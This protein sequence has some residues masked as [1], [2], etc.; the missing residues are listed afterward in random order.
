[1]FPTILVV[2]DRLISYE[3]RSSFTRLKSAEVLKGK[4]MKLTFALPQNFTYQAGMYIQLNCDTVAKEEWHPFTLTSAPEEGHL[5]VHIRCPDEL[6]WCSAMRRRLAEEPAKNIGKGSIDIKNRFKVTYGRF[7]VPGDDGSFSR[8]YRVQ[9]MGKDGRVAKSFDVNMKERQKE[10]AAEY[11]KKFGDTKGDTE[12]E[13]IDD[14]EGVSISLKKASSL[15]SLA[16]IVETRPDDVV[17]CAIDGPHGTPSEMV[18]KHRVCVLVGAGIGVTPWA[19]ILKSITLRSRAPVDKQP[20]AGKQGRAKSAGGRWPAKEAGHNSES[21]EED[22]YMACSRVHFYWLCR[23]KEEFDWFHDMLS[24][25]IRNRNEEA[26]E[27]NLFQTGEMEANQETPNDGFR[28][29]YGRPS[30]GKLLPKMAD[31]Y[32]GDDVGVFLCGPGPIREDL[33]KNCRKANENDKGSTFTL[34]AE[35]F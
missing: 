21:D 26:I 32:P 10:D 7:S 4:V 30:W 3:R 13:K 22:A 19:S 12:G 5:S 28:H 27:V 11:D 34:Y 15:M 20:K 6:D 33:R 29:F 14:T 9:E 18:W 1:M 23:T 31:Q 24:V 16:D 25:A 35:N 17:R 2:C 8:P